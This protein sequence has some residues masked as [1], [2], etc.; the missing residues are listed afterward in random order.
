M[1]SEEQNDEEEINIINTHY[2]K[3]LFLGYESTHARLS[4]PGNLSITDR[5]E[6]AGDVINVIFNSD[7]FQNQLNQAFLRC[8]NRSLIFSSHRGSIIEVL[9]GD[10]KKNTIEELKRMSFKEVEK[11]KQPNGLLSVDRVGDGIRATAKLFFSLFDPESR[12]I[13]IDEPEVFIHPKQ[14]MKIAKELKTLVKKN[15]KQLFLSTH[16]ATFLSGLVDTKENEIEINI[17]YIKDHNKI[18]PLENYRVGDEKIRPSTKQQKYIQSLFYDGTIFTEGVNDRCFY[19]NTIEHIFEKQLA[20]KDILYTDLGGASNAHMQIARFVKDSEI[21]SV[22][23]FDKDVISKDKKKNQKLIQTYESLSG[24][25]DLNEMI[26][27]LPKNTEEVIT[28]L[29]KHGIF[30]VPCGAPE[31]FIGGIKKTDIG[32]PYNLIE[33]MTKNPT[34]EFKLFAEDIIDFLLKKNQ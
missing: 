29:K 19:E 34:Q 2:V 18:I 33:A 7:D 6:T 8:F 22:I 12:I 11:E 16:D 1:L 9:V 3:K 32:F 30:I 17:F 28:K 15:K 4:T 27:N 23:I 21:N 10:M 5:K 24:K 25:T 26:S 20:Q 31:N 13:F 14:K